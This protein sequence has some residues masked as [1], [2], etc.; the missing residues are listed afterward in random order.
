[1]KGF[2]G[3][4]CSWVQQFT[5]GGNVNIKVNDQMGSYF[6]A[7]KG[8]RQGDPMSPILFNIVADMLAI[9]IARAKEAGQIDGVIPHLI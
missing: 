3:K 9:L 8:L 2:C 6:Q 5:Q 1:M 4:W 7:K